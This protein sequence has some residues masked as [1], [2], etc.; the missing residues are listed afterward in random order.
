DQLA[1]VSGNNCDQ[2][3]PRVRELGTDLK[4]WYDVHQGF[5]LQRAKENIIS[6]GVRN[7]RY[8]HDKVKLGSEGLRLIPI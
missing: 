8:L 1:I 2:N 7:T 6:Y 3:I 4:Y 5:Y